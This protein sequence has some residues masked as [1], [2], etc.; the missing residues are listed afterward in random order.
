ML[1]GEHA[2][3]YGYPAIVAAINQR[4]SVRVS[5]RS[6]KMICL[7]TGITD[8]VLCERSHLP[9]DGKLRFVTAAVLAISELAEQGFD[10]CVTSQI[11]PTLGLGSSAAVTVASLAALSAYSGAENS[12]QGLHSRAL[13]IVRAIQGRG[14]GA[15]LAASTYGNVLSYRQPPSAQ[16]IPA[17]SGTY[18]AYVDAL[19]TPPPLSLQYSGYKTP[20]SEVLA[21]ISHAR[22]GNEA[23]FDALFARMGT[24]AET[25]IAAAQQEQWTEFAHCMTA[26]QN[27]MEDLG[28]S[29]ATLNAMIARGKTA[30][31]VKISGSGLGD[32]VVA[33]GRPPAGFT[34]VGIDPE[35][36]RIHV[37]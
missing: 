11:N 3:V 18:D 33:M 26:Y 8:T 24:C 35:G 22:H 29:D 23:R 25:A 10:L 4:V 14:S 37:D 7:D 6:D 2:V 30:M 28:V 5:A 36:V 19:P 17:V 13:A 1:I 15:D 32:C 12:M 21:K 9:V 16:D 27:M 20:T 31:A 34:P